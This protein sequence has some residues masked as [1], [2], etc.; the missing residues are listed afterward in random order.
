M[1]GINNITPRIVQ[2]GLED[3]TPIYQNNSQPHLRPQLDDD[4]ADKKKHSSRK[5]L[6]WDMVNDENRIRN[7]II[8]A[9]DKIVRLVD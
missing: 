8:Y 2:E 4:M 7:A 1:I 5:E 6:R 3:I 9:V